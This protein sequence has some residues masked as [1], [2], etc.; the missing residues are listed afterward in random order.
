MPD[1]NP[2]ASDLHDFVPYLMAQV[3]SLVAHSFAPHLKQA[4]ITLHLRR[5][6]LVMHIDGP[7]TLIDSSGVIGV[8]TST[9]S[10]LVGRMLENRLL[11]Q[12][13]SREGARTVQISLR[14][15][16]HILF[17]KLWLETDKAQEVVASP[18]SQ[19]R[20]CAV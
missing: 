8:K 18:F 5:V 2:E 4:G 19:T 6:L 3:G 16:G 13:R 15:E 1:A 14:R 9:L 11:S 20:A 10:R 7:P 17:C 12:R